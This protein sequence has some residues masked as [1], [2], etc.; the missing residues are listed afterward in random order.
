MN[1]IKVRSPQEYLKQ[2]CLEGI[3]YLPFYYY[4][5]LAKINIKQLKSLFENIHGYTAI[6]AR[7]ES[8]KSKLPITLKNTGTSAY[9]AKVTLKEKLLQGNLDITTD[10][11]TLRYLL[12]VL[13]SLDS[14][15]IIRNTLLEIYKNPL[16]KI[17]V[18]SDFRLALCYLDYIKNKS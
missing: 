1:Q 16:R 11:K 4:C 13:R 5:N 12:Y 14:D 3:K 9:K 15:E 10:K 18:L 17:G 7:L 6:L 8:D 2:I